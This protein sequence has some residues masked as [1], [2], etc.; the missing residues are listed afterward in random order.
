VSLVMVYLSGRS[1]RL[2]KLYTREGGG[3]G[4]RK[5]VDDPHH[6]GRA[7]SSEGGAAVL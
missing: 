6:L 5:K 2:G 4:N 7:P 1:E 3:G